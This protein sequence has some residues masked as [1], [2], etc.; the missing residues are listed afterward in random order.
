[1]HSR[2][3]WKDVT[4]TNDALASSDP[5]MI[6]KVEEVDKLFAEQGKWVINQG[7]AMKEVNDRFEHLIFVLK[8]GM[9]I[10]LDSI[11]SFIFCIIE[12]EREHDREGRLLQAGVTNGTSGAAMEVTHTSTLKEIIKSL[13]QKTKK[14]DIKIWVERLESVDRIILTLQQYGFVSGLD[15]VDY[16]LYMIRKWREACS[17][18]IDKLKGSNVASSA[19]SLNSPADD[20]SVG[21]ESNNYARSV[22]SKKIEKKVVKKRASSMVVGNMNPYVATYEHLL[23]KEKKS[24]AKQTA[25]PTLAQTMG[26]TQASAPNNDSQVSNLV[27]KAITAAGL[28]QQ[29]ICRLNASCTIYIYLIVLTQGVQSWI[30]LQKLKTQRHCLKLMK[31]QKKIR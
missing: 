20:G 4:A 31:Q 14:A 11:V 25:T 12:M 16:L 1:M 28:A 21:E 7:K 10:G 13:Q 29:G 2:I 27:L 17:L 19:A 6:K 24:E 3:G 26:I 23:A 18:S 30:H 15:E 22:V 5:A 9:Y 8:E